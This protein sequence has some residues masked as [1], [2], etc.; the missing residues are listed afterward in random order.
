MAA[1]RTTYLLEG[2]DVPPSARRSRVSISPSVD[3]YYVDDHPEK[4]RLTERSKQIGIPLD[5]QN[6]KTIFRRRRPEDVAGIWGQY[7]HLTMPRSLGFHPMEYRLP[8]PDTVRRFH[9]PEDGVVEP[10]CNR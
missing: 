10:T 1:T 5:A 6:Q 2:G 4:Q 3:R 9:V 8:D 7:A